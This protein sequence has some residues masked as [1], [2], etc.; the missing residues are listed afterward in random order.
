MTLHLEAAIAR[1]GAGLSLH[2]FLEA[3]RRQFQEL[4]AEGV[5]IEVLYYNEQQ[6]YLEQIDQVGFERT[7]KTMQV[8]PVKADDDFAGKGICPYV[9]W[10][11][12]SVLAPYVLFDRRYKAVLEVDDTKSELAVPVRLGDRL[13]GVLN[14]ESTEARTFDN[15]HLK[16]FE[17][18]SAL[19]A[20]M[21]EYETFRREDE[22]LREAIE[23]LSLLVEPAAILKRVLDQVLHLTG[24]DC[25]GCVFVP[26]AEEGGMQR[27]RVAINRGLDLV[28]DEERDLESLGVI[29]RAVLSPKGQEYWSI[30]QG[31]EGYVPL[32]EGI[33]SEFVTVM[34]FGQRTIGLIDVESPMPLI[35]ERFQRAI[36]RFA[37]HAAAMVHGLQERGA[38]E[39]RSI[40]RFVRHEAHNLKNWAWLLQ[41]NVRDGDTQKAIAD[42]GY[43]QNRLRDME[44]L[45]QGFLEPPRPVR[46]QRVL[47]EVEHLANQM[48]VT[49]TCTGT[50]DLIVSGNVVGLGWLFE[51]MLLNTSK[52]RDKKSPQAWLEVEE[53]DGRGCL[54]YWDDGQAPEDAAE[55]QGLESMRAL[56]REYGWEFERGRHADGGMLYTCKFPCSREPS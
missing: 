2:E 50:P 48:K 9:A 44:G 29:K 19:L 42:A 37:D 10:T 33:E 25:L 4:G 49:L 22:F 27:L 41:G 52:H 1:Y 39:R 15:Q 47:K 30:D 13:I 40:L 43:V 18:L 55:R 34:R 26:V 14:L 24:S 3:H 20:L 36:Q 32:A 8:R 53:T 23:G 51:N 21:I 46:L 45:V 35:S 56:C 28:V 6:K 17:G 16:Y 11:G 7:Q 5:R 38:L 54:R 31:L 12:E